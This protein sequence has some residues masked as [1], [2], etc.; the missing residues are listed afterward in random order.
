MSMSLRHQ[1]D[2]NG[3]NCEESS[4]VVTLRK[5]LSAYLHRH[6]A[7]GT[8]LE[9]LL[10]RRVGRYRNPLAERH[11]EIDDPETDVDATALA[12]R[13]NSVLQNPRAV[14]LPRIGGA[15]RP[16]KERKSVE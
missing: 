15:E 9:E 12:F 11:M 10:S 6:H 3:Q 16:M 1:L 2:K 13:I 8:L 14:S 5:N 4:R 7:L